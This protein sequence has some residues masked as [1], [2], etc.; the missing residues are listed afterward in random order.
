MRERERERERERRKNRC[1]HNA[2]LPYSRNWHKLVQVCIYQ[3]KCRVVPE[4]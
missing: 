2:L 1:S 4:V 3:C